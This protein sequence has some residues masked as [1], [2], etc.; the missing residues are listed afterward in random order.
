MIVE[1][2]IIF[3]YLFIKKNNIESLQMT[4]ESVNPVKID[5]NTIFESERVASAYNF[6]KEKH[7]Q[8]PPRKSGEPYITHPIEVYK[9]LR[10][11]WGIKNENYLIAA[12]LHDVIEDTDV[13]PDEI[14]LKFGDEVLELVSGVT[15]L[16]SSTDKETLKK[17]LD[18]SYINPGVAL[19]KLADRLH[20]MRTL[21]FMKPEKRIAKSQETLD[22][23]T[24]LAESLGL[25]GTKTE[26][27]DLCFMYLDPDEYQKTLNSLESDPRLSLD[28]T[29]HL[30]SRI[31]QLLTDNGIGGKVETRKSGSWILN[32]K[33]EKMALRGKSGCD[34]FEDINDVISFRVK[35]KTIDDCYQTLL[36]I[37]D[38]F[39][40]M[41]DYD[42]FDEFIGANKRINGYQALQTTINFPQGPVEIAIM[43]EEMEDFNNNGII[44]L[45]NR[46]IDIK[47]Y[48]FKSVFTSTEKLRFLPK[49]ATGVD[50]A[51]AISPRVLA[52]AESINIDGVDRPLTVVIP[53]ASTLRINLGESRRAPLKNLEDY[54]L[55]Q[56][57][58]TILEQRILED[59]D[60]LLIQ[61]KKT[62]ESILIPRGLLVL[63][64]VGDS[65]NPLL[66][67]LGCQSIGDLYFMVGNNSIKKER[68]EQELDLAGITKE[69]LR[70]TSIRISGPDQ[71]KIL[72]DVVKKISEM[73]KNIVHI[74]QKNSKGKFNIRILAEN[75]SQDEE[76]SLRQY[77]INDSRFNEG[78]VV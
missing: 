52:E 77:L 22:I 36:V 40:N 14:K 74:E 59:R 53:N 9:I 24:R 12:F 27:E 67:K 76:Q 30:T 71:P 48:V 46:G 44:S 18:K 29:C 62:M 78:L 73:D 45:I 2:V 55:P 4:I 21:E 26:L 63:F 6:A 70:I 35:L 57:R 11:E 3:R 65:I 16:K 51:A 72:V 15:K 5:K 60:E 75:M 50:F 31:E 61:G 39:G 56:T 69:N 34:D 54:C 64:D 25:W 41:V 19:I 28:F 66:Y 38:D 68:L 8:C 49:N 1:I 10:N 32:K 43:T 37:H 20:N 33:R 17:V 47:D 7:D 13:T 58:R 23:Y 42:R